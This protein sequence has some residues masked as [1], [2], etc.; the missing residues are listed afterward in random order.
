AERAV[1]VHEDEVREVVARVLRQSAGR[2]RHRADEAVVEIIRR[3]AA[4]GE[5]RTLAVERVNGGVARGVE[6]V[7]E[8]VARGVV[9]AEDRDAASAGDVRA[10]PRGVAAPRARA[11]V[12]VEAVAAGVRAEVVAARGDDRAVIYAEEL[13]A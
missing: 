9:R 7:G 8:R 10:D 4:R 12:V 2:A 6:A 5:A 11:A 3:L 13:V 1:G